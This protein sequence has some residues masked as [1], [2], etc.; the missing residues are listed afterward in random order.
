[1]KTRKG[2]ILMIAL[3]SIGLMF[4]M[5]LVMLDHHKS[6]NRLSRRIVEDNVAQAAAEA[7]INRAIY[8]IKQ[9]SSWETGI[10]GAGLSHSGAS[11]T[12]T[13]NNAGS[14][15]YS[16]NNMMGAGDVT[17]YGNRVVPRGYIHLV[18][19]G[20]YEGNTKIEEA[21]ISTSGGALFD[22]A[23]FVSNT[24]EMNGNVIVDSFDSSAGDYNSTHSNSDGNIRTNSDGNNIVN[25][26][27]RV[28]VYGDVG[29]GPDGTEENTLK[30]TG[31]SSYQSFSTS[32]PQEFPFQEAPITPS[33]GSI[34]LSNAQNVTIS[35]GTY[36]S[37]SL[38]GRSRI[39]L[40]PGDY[41][42]LDG[43]HFSGQATVKLEEGTERTNVYTLGDIHITGSAN[44][45]E[46]GKSTRLIIY[47][48]PDTDSVHLGGLGTGTF[49]LYTPAADVHL[50][51]NA[52]IY[53]AIVGNSL[54]INGNNA[55]IHFDR[56]MTN[57]GPT[58]GG[59]WVINCQWTSGI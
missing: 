40:Q 32:S 49:G 44:I 53:G 24:M 10:D 54:K 52:Q 39:I 3:L 35:P 27:G 28:Q 22:A 16:T 23:V 2:Y 51:G 13:F 58:G 19:V 46:D 15:P 17:G 31:R 56:S 8:E 37:L 14:I 29:V 38:S 11:Y 4:F 42:F 20:E 36:D 6:E 33:L 25:L 45:N 30:V 9:D 59:N 50:G 7:G 43:I 26:K 18:S 34:T 5:G 57:D 41:V 55:S 1:M 47:G 21:L 12:V 48:G